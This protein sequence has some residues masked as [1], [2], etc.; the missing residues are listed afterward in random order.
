METRRGVKWH[1]MVALIPQVGARLLD[2][3]RKEEGGGRYHVTIT[4]QLP[5][6]IQCNIALF[7]IVTGTTER[8]IHTQYVVSLVDCC[9]K[10]VC[11]EYT[12]MGAGRR[13]LPDMISCLM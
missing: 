7:L 6:L 5:G 10:I 3:R 8:I 4:R 9:G 2:A 12:K 1:K 11:W 13:V